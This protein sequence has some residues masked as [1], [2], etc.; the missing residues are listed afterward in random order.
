MEGAWN[1]RPSNA[2]HD[3]TRHAM[4]RS[5]GFSEAVQM[6][7]SAFGI[8]IAFSYVWQ[9]A[10]FAEILLTVSLGFLLHELGHRF[11]AQRFGA[12]AEYRMWTMGL[13]A[14]VALAVFFGFIFAAP[15]AVYISKDLKRD[16]S[17]KVAIAGPLVNV[18]L[19]IVFL[20]LAGTITGASSMLLTGAR[21]NAFLAAFNL[22]PMNPF[23]GWKVWR[24]DKAWWGAAFA[25]SALLALII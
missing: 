21:T 5:I 19:A 2:K 24:W 7:V 25:V 9:G 4:F 11:V 10:S 6:I 16:E 3:R 18:A 20:G 8:A 14:A 22:V 17:G 15:G 1:I 23:D 13:V 12:H